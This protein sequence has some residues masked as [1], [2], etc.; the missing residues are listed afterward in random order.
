MARYVSKEQGIFVPYLRRHVQCSGG[1]ICLVWFLFLFSGGREKGGGA[2]FAVFGIV[3]KDI[4]WTHPVTAISSCNSKFV[5][6]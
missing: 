6:A 5:V 2:G 4:E 1:L 3:L